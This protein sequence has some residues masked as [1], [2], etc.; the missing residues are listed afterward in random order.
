M[1]QTQVA[2]KEERAVVQFK[3]E[4]IIITYEDVKR[5]ICPLADAK[6]IGLFLR[7]CQVLQLNPFANEVFLI[8][9]SPTEKAQQVIAIESYLKAAEANPNYDGHE[10]G[11]I[12]RDS[13]G[14]LEFRPGAFVLDEERGNLVGGWARVYR[15][16]RSH[17]Y[18]VSVHKSECIKHRKDGSVTEFWQEIKQPWMLRKVA[19]A[20]A[21]VEAHP[22][23]FSG[24]VSNVEYEELPKEVI[25]KLPQPRGESE[26]GELPVG[27]VKNGQADWSKFW[28]HQAERGIDGKRAHQLLKVESIKVNLFERGKTLEDIDQMISDALEWEKTIGAR[29][30]IVEK[31]VEVPT[32]IPDETKQEPVGVPAPFIP[33][34]ASLAVVEKPKKAGPPQKP[35]RD[36]TTINSIGDLL[37]ACFFDFGLQPKQVFA[38]L[39]VK[40]QADISELPSQCYIRIAGA[41]G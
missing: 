28:A 33:E 14:K 35:K 15:K 6:E 40:S 13:G 26:E 37:Q 21:L 8:K 10:A 29:A 30:P 34:P 3:G 11:V 16:D 23:L 22:S 20:R 24:L 41:R 12:L 38:E 7:T 32:P 9:Y 25:T 31:P 17:P 1:E 27:F 39:N 5:F 4:G 18:Y 19:L 36:P 2:T